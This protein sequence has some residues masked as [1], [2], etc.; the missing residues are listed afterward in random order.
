MTDFLHSVL[1]EVSDKIVQSEVQDLDSKL[2]NASDPNK[3]NEAT[4]TL[5]GILDNIPWALLGIG[6][7]FSSEADRL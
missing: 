2:S 7:D 5:K 1:G 6:G 3:S 4:S